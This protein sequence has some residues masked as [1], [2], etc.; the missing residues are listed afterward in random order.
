MNDVET[1]NARGE[2]LIAYTARVLMEVDVEVEFWAPMHATPERLE[3]LAV[4]EFERG[5]RLP[6]GWEPV[7]S[8]DYVE[9]A[10]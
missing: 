8:V 1:Y 4:E 2:R 3:H 5:L 9:E 6:E 7:V 10:Q